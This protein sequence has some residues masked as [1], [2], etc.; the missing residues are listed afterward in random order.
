MKTLI[1][2]FIDR[3]RGR[4]RTHIDLH[5][6]SGEVIIRQGWRRVRLTHAQYLRLEQLKGWQQ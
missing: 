3:M 2:W 4:E 6:Q 1:Q 5:A